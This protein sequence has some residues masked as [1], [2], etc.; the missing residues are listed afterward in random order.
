MID[1]NINTEFY[2]DTRS[3]TSKWTGYKGLSEVYLNKFNRTS[4]KE[5]KV[6]MAKDGVTEFLITP[7]V[8]GD[9]VYD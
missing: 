3:I 9:Y 6:K 5:P 2:K 8:W 7:F 1:A 4:S